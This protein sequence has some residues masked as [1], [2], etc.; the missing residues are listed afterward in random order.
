[1]ED[2]AVLLLIEVVVVDD[3]DDAVFVVVVVAEDISLV[4]TDYNLYD[5]PPVSR[6]NVSLDSQCHPR[7]RC[8]IYG[9]IE[10]RT[11]TRSPRQSLDFW[12]LPGSCTDAVVVRKRN[13]DYARTLSVALGYDKERAAA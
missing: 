11:D 1:M 9:M 4:D 7:T 6:R 5:C 13:Y 12:R 3:V 10:D 2:T 8:W